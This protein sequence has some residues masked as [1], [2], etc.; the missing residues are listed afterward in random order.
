VVIVVGVRG[1]GTAGEGEAFRRLALG[2]FTTRCKF[3]PEN[4]LMNRPPRPKLPSA[5]ERALL[6]NDTLKSLYP[7]AAC[8]LNFENPLQLLVA[9]ILSAQCTD[10]R[11]NLVTPALFARYPSAHHFAQSELEE[12][13]ELIRST[14]FFRNKAKNIQGCCLAIV[15]RF[16]GNVPSRLEDLTT[17]AGVGRK[18][19]NVVLGNAFQTPGITV[20]T[21]VGRLSRRLGLTK[22]S[23]PVKVELDLMKI[24]PQPDW[25]NFSHG[26][27]LH[28]RQICHSRKPRC[29]SCGLANL[30]PKVGV[31][32]GTKK[33]GKG[34]GTKSPRMKKNKENE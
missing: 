20:D 29:E 22:M 12:L 19:A 27:I 11:V 9:T 4:Q 14:G 21:H 18:T 28:G 26:L 6:I 13:Q 24:I 7:G 3:H 1:I 30:C 10:V 2:V 34:A 5:R 17:L 8:A 23:D 32:S 15:E 31:A 33:S 25:T 16:G